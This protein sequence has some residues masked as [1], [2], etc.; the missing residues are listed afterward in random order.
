[1][2]V[3]IEYDKDKEGEF[4]RI[5]DNSIGMSSKELQ[6]AVIVGKPP[7]VVSGRSRYGLG[8]KTGASWI[9]DR[10]TV[11]TKKFGYTRTQ[12]I[13]VNIPRI[14]SG[15]RDLRHREV[16]SDDRKGHGTTIEI[17]ALHRKPTSRT[18]G[19]IKEY[20]KSIYRYD[21][22]A[23]KLVLKWNDEE[24]IWDDKAF[25][26]RFLKNKKGEP[27]RVNFRFK[28]GKKNVH[29][30]AAV[31]EKGSRKDA[32][33]SIIQ[34]GRV[35]DGWPNA[36]R[37]ETI[38][39]EQEGGVNDLVNQRLLGEIFLEGFEVSHTKDEILF[40]EGEQEQLEYRLR[41]RLE[42]LVTVAKEYRKN[43]DERVQMNILVAKKTAVGRI[44]KEI[45]SKQM[46]NAMVEDVPDVDVW[47][48]TSKIL[49]QE[50][51]QKFKPEVSARI[52][53]TD[54]SLFLVEDMSPNDPY[55][56]IE[57]T[58]SESSIIVIINTTHP[59]WGELNNAESI[60]NFIRHC[61]YDGV[62]EWKAYFR[63]GNVKPNTIKL[64]KDGLLRL[65]M[66]IG[67]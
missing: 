51:I 57:S 28:V 5:R 53:N 15:K 4:F 44:Q 52:G 65:P 16:P 58:E 47:V 23:G 38:F 56:I 22:K 19:K 42:H 31:F 62:A 60:L 54:V 13:T 32:G 17:R 50:V 34:H 27:V 30:W 66:K 55:V 59:H 1:M 11:E 29:G 45:S 6:D 8:L 25:E 49:R 10:W 48:R 63:V 67:D 24:L 20:L 43:A 12:H 14:A 26:S 33:F 64:I 18:I 3:S 2:T 41:K 39:G 37:P 36:Y 40:D 35:I 21:L 61:V 7:K 46:R 9:G